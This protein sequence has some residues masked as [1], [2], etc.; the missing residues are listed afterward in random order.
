MRSSHHSAVIHREANRSPWTVSDARLRVQFQHKLVALRIHHLLGH[1][2]VRQLDNRN[3]QGYVVLNQLEGTLI[4]NRTGQQFVADQRP[5][6]DA[7]TFLFV[8]HDWRLA[9]IRLEEGAR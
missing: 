1:I 8:L 5:A 9:E 6:L 3:Q 7:A 2:K 4:G